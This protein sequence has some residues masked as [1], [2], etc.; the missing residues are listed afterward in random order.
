MI[1]FNNTDTKIF[2]IVICAILAITTVICFF[3][4][5]ILVQE[6]YVLRESLLLLQGQIKE[7]NEHIEILKTVLE[8][9]SPEQSNALTYA[10]IG[11]FTFGFLSY[12]FCLS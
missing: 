5:I 7:A 4:I 9:S 8:E 12:L 3:Y 10:V 2:F 6:L 11:G 1:R